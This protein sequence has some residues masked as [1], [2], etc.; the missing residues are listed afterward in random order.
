MENS[1]ILPTNNKI[2]NIFKKIFPKYIKR[3]MINRKMTYNKIMLN[4]L[5]EHK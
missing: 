5:L 3:R 4:R 1:N 2:G